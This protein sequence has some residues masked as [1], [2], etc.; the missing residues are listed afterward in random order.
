MKKI[1]FIDIDGTLVE[2]GEEKEFIPESAIKA[3]KTT[4]A[5]RNYV[6]LCTGRSKPEIFQFILDVGIDGIIGA[7]GAYIETNKE[8]LYHE[9]L[10]TKVV[11]KIITYFD[12]NMFDYY[13]E[14]NDGLYGSKNLIKRLQYLIYGDIDHDDEAKKR[15]ERNQSHFIQSIDDQTKPV[16][17][18]INKICFLEQPN[19][20]FQQIKILFENEV[21]VHHC[22]VPIFG[23]NS[24]E[25]SLKDLHKAQAIE[26]VLNHLNID[27]KDTYAYG[28]GLNDIEMLQYCH[29]GIAMGN[30]KQ[31]LKE[32]ADEVTDSVIN[33]GIYNSM[34][35]HGLV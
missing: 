11:E 23:D 15:L 20:P 35:K 31:Q 25:F 27:K 28:D 5:K 10:P 26:K 22:T 14:A 1:I 4:R 8:V 19:I 2:Q 24:G 16:L 6:Y 9:M 33:N 29:Y 3:I 17:D 21:T 34:K 18:N 13:L 30:A 32:I 12:Q 7:G